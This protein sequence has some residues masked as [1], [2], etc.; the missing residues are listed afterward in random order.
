MGLANA[1]LFLLILREGVFQQPQAITLIEKWPIYSQT[2]LTFSFV[3]LL[4]DGFKYRM[5]LS[6][7]E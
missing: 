6:M 1:I 2:A 5:V 3:P 4:R 7:S